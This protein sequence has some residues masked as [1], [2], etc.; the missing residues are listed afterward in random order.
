MTDDRRATVEAF[1][2]QARNTSEI[3]RLSTDRPVDTRGCATGAFARNP[4][5][6]QP[7]PIYLADYVL[8]TYG[9]GAVM[10]VPGHDERDFE[11]AKKYGLPVK[12][13]SRFQPS[14]SSAKGAL[15]ALSFTTRRIRLGSRGGAV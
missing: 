3:D 14:A 6:G 5:T 8:A 2:E 15:A 4:F 12:P 11:F 7:V 1:V 9:T 13:A 10:G